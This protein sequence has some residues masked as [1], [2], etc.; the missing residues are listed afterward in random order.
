MHTKSVLTL[1]LLLPIFLFAQPTTPFN[2]GANF[3]AWFQED[4]VGEINFRKY[5][6]QDFIEAQSLGIDVIRLP[7]NLEGMSSGAPNYT[8]DANFLCMLD[9][10]VSWAEELGIHLILDNHTFA[11]FTNTTVVQ[12]M[13]LKVW[14]QM[15]TQ[16]ESTSTLIYYEIQNEP[17]D[18]TDA[19]W[20]SIQQAV[21]TQIRTIDTKHTLII[22]GAGYNG[23][24]NLN[25]MPVYSDNNL[26]Y[27]FH[28][29]DPFLFTHQGA[30]WVS[31]SMDLVS[32]IPFPYNASSMPSLD[33][34]YLGTWIESVYNGYSS[35]GTVAHI[36]SLLDG[37]EN[38]QTT[39]N[40]PVY[41]GEFGVYIPN[42]DDSER[43][44]WYQ[45]VR[46]ALEERNLDW[47]IWDYKG[48]FGIFEGGTSELFEH[49]LNIPLLNALGFNEPTQTPFSIQADE[50]G[51]TIYDDY[52]G[53]N[54]ANSSYGSGTRD[55]A[56]TTSPEAGKF[57]I[58]WDNA[59]QY[60]TTSF[61]FAPDRDFS[62]L[63][64]DGFAL[65]FDVL[66]ST[67]NTSFQVR[68]EDTDTG[69]NDRPWRMSYTIDQNLVNWNGEWQ[70]VRIP[71]NQFFETGAWENAYYAP[72]G[73]FDWTAVDQFR[74]VAEFGTISSIRFDN[75]EITVNLEVE[76][77][78]MLQGAYN[79]TDMSTALSTSLPTAQ[80]YTE[81]YDG[82]E[83]VAAIPSND[84][85]DWV[86]VELRYPENV[87]LAS[88][89]AFLRKDGMVVDLDGISPVAFEGV[90]RLEYYVAVRHRNH[91]GVMTT[92]LV[93]FQ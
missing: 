6:K 60:G 54:I 39:R 7:I 70:H 80:P 89:A 12:D 90:K 85:V 16:Y 76:S 91:L 49:D 58:A 21:V 92:D 78:I 81:V 46:E 88:R 29:Y 32:G 10:V 86:L 48:G 87:V 72:E 14:T 83:T 18:I 28:F 41:C 63:L 44:Y 45:Q 52:L 62:Q 69:A 23:F 55:F 57:C 33:A 56:S 61:N 2:K 4:S 37:V 47:T 68:F 17:H 71:L 5:T 22:G 3:S 38:F 25:Q 93:Q 34:S 27:T 50:E 30:T 67:A 13:L 20:N 65:E 26:I 77:K 43:V 79:G 75:I 74:I 73:L 24:S 53:V 51:L 66:G 8:L 11:D 59:Q 64:T 15:A 31:P 36:E 84:I 35:D 9:E 42:S 1:F 40:V 82:T 19:A